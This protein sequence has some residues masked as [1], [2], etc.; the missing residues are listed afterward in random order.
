MKLFH[1]Y[2]DT[3]KQYMS[4]HIIVM[5]KTIEEAR[6][7]ACIEFEL[8]ARREDSHFTWIFWNGEFFD[9]GS[10]DEWFEIITKFKNDIEKEPIDNDGAIFIMG[11]E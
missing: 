1:W 4:G 11:S 7:V 10:Q 6:D 8:W 9:E 5:A 2:S 3:L